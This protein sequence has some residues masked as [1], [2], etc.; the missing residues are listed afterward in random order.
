MMQTDVKS[1]QSS[2]NGQM[3]LGRTRLKGFVAATGI[4][5]IFTFW[6]STTAPV[7][8]TYARTTT[9]ITVS[10]T[11][12]GLVVGQKVGLQFAVVSSTSAT[13]GN[14]TVATV[15]DANTFTVVDANSGTVAASTAVTYV[16]SSTG[17]SPWMFTYQAAA[18]ATNAFLQFPGEGIVA[19]VGIYVNG[20]FSSVS[21]FYG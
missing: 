5:G 9:I 4:S 20:T 10:S 7:T 18:V 21:I 11:A 13:S 6:N 14:Y 1:G 17:F 19:D 8:A 2:V 12:H 15:A 3:V 16:A